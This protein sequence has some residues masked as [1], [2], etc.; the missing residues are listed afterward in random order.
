MLVVNWYM[1]LR[2]FPPVP[3]AYKKGKNIKLMLGQGCDK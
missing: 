1:Q 2:I 3:T